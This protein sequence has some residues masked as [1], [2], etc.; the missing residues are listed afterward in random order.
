EISDFLTPSDPAVAIPGSSGR[1]LSVFAVPVNVPKRYSMRGWHFERGESSPGGGSSK[2]VSLEEVGP[3]SQRT[4]V[5][6][7]PRRLWRKRKRVGILHSRHGT[8]A[9]LSLGRRRP[10]RHLRRQTTSVLCSGAVE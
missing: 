5:G 4:A 10:G 7:R 3:L 9:C 2:E 8:L 1:Q 6:H